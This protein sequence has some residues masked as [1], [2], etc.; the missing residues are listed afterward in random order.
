MMRFSISYLLNSPTIQRECFRNVYRRWVSTKHR[1]YP[2]HQRFVESWMETRE[3]ERESR[4]RVAWMFFELRG[5]IAAQLH[6]MPEL[7]VYSIEDPHWRQPR[8]N[9]RSLSIQSNK[10]SVGMYTRR[11]HSKIHSAKPISHIPIYIVGIRV[12]GEILSWWILCSSHPLYIT[13]F[14]IQ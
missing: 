10:S 12:T 5:A 2:R 11:A 8:L 6:Y 1:Y 3:R 13:F 7:N 4:R 14:Q 9:C